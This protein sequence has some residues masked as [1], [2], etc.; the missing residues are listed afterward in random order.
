MRRITPYLC[1]LLALFSCE[2]VVEVDVPEEE[3]RLIVE[4]LVR[5]DES[6]ALFRPIVK[7]SLTS[8]FFGSIP[9]TGLTDISI[10]N[11][12]LST[13]GENSFI[14]LE[15]IEEGSGLYQDP[16]PV[17]LDFF[18]N[19]ELILQL[20]HEGRL[21]FARAEYARAVPIDN[22][23]Q[24]DETLFDDDDVE[25][26]ITITDRGDTDDYYVMDFG[27]G[28]F[29]ALEDEFFNGQEFNFSYF[30]ERTLEPGDEIT[31]SILG[32]DRSFFNYMDLLVE[33][34]FDNQGVFET[35][36]ATVR[37]NIFDV[38]DL[39]NIDVFDNVE[40]PDLFPL[41]YFAIVQEYKQTITIE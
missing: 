1:I 6:Q 20:T 28:E 21:Y 17:G 4:A 18:A 14:V 8:S 41:G 7:V 12:A 35:P 16:D 15:E 38:T 3:P 40:Q 11:L 24:G 2:D 9:V 5:I 34:T 19:G 26:E 10:L 29:L 32:A 30:P 13:S 37:G 22:L 36:V 39:D 31:V 25:L 23:Q 27:E 33:Q